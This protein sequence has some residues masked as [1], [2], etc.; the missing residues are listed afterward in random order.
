M[1]QRDA[2]YTWLPLFFCHAKFSGTGG[3]SF[4]N[5]SGGRIR[6]PASSS[7]PTSVITT[8]A[9]IYLNPKRCFLAGFPCYQKGN[10][11]SKRL[12]CSHPAGTCFSWKRLIIP[13][14]W[15]AWKKYQWQKNI[16]I[17]ISDINEHKEG[18]NRWP[19]RGDT[20]AGAEADGVLPAT[21]MSSPK[22]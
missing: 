1:S 15:S 7:F 8:K 12:S 3:S 5:P 14:L 16:R 20:V 10:R 6:P 2:A 4:N 13:Q 9:N 19:G 21:C 22:V 11:N 18:V 17:K